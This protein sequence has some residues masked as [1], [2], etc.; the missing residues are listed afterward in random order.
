MRLIADDATI[1]I[2]F[3]IT[4]EEVYTMFWKKKAVH[5]IE[6]TDE[7]KRLLLDT[8]IWFKNKL[9]REGRYT[10]AVDDAILALVSQ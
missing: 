10:D 5:R 8:L 7:E 3:Y 1:T 6:L 9:T 4:R 2:R